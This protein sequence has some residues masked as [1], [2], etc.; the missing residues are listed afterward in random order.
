MI[1]LSNLGTKQ[2]FFRCLSQAI[3]FI[4]LFLVIKSSENK[5]R[6]Y[7]RC[8]LNEVYIKYCLPEK[9]QW[10]QKVQERKTFLKY[11][12]KEQTHKHKTVCFFY[13]K[14]PL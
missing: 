7:V 3:T 4:V 13:K 14:Y 5:I 11:D 2:H 9:I 12:I 1:V 6:T 10:K 8:C